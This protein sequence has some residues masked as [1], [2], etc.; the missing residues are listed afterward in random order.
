MVV[1]S[2]AS[3][4][5]LL[6]LLG[7]IGFA[8]SQASADPYEPNDGISQATPLPGGAAY[9]ATLDTANDADWFSFKL[10]ARQQI[11]ISLGYRG[12][13]T[14]ARF[15]DGTGGEI[16][17][18]KL[19]DRRG[20]SDDRTTFLTLSFAWTTPGVADRYYIAFNEDERGNPYDRGGGCDVSVQVDPGS[21]VDPAPEPVLPVVDVPEP[22][23]TSVTAYGPLQSGTRYQGSDDTENDSDW[24]YFYA[25]P[26]R[27]ISVRQIAPFGCS[28]QPR[29]LKAVYK[30]PGT[31]REVIGADTVEEG[32]DVVTLK[33]PEIPGYNNF[34]VTKTFV[35]DARGGRYDV[36]FGTTYD[37]LFGS[38]IGCP[39]LLEIAPAD[40]VL[41]TPTLRPAAS[42]ECTAARAQR[43]RA[44]VTV[45]TLKRRVRDA[46]QSSRRSRAQRLLKQARRDLKAADGVVASRCRT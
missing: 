2:I 4:S 19:D 45:S 30:D 8:C 27:T 20:R 3:L 7:S 12:C 39:W 25:A 5:A 40:A 36:E 37:S 42:R 23:E 21:A 18:F 35:S 17:Q 22:N 6:G 34:D 13:D 1:R 28:S 44:A 46:R 14:Y 33:G 31:G 32:G 10:P 43:A 11:V 26:R 29:G 24:S 16:K 38:T 15:N 9:V 41:A